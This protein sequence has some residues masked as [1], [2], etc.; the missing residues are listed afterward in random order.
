MHVPDL[1]LQHLEELLIQGVSEDGQA[2][3]VQLIRLVAHGTILM[4]PDAILLMGYSPKL[5]ARREK[6][7]VKLLELAHLPPLFKESLK[8]INY[9]KTV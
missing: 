7:K 2:L 8:D 5:A 3:E 6:G 4:E 1:P 9:I